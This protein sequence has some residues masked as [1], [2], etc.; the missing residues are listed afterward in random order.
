MKKN[1]LL[2]S[3]CVWMNSCVT[4]EVISETAPISAMKTKDLTYQ[5]NAN[6]DLQKQEIPEEAFSHV[7][8]NIRNEMPNLYLIVESIQ[9]CNIH[10]SGTYHFPTEFS[11][12]YWETDTTQTS[13]TIET[14]AIELAPHQEFLCPQE[15]TLSFIPQSNRAWN[16]IILPQNCTQTYL[17]VNCKIYNI[18]NTDKGYQEGKE[19]LIWGDEKGNCA[20]LAIPLSVHFLSNQEYSI[21]VELST[22]CTWYNINGSQPVPAL[23]PITFDVSVN[24]WEEVSS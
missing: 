1:L 5:Y 20:K 22:D 21:T 2:L 4:D 10:L 17:L 24:D 19:A 9:I 6:E 13:L 12:G 11:K 23:V 16:P 8:L 15:G 18:Y 7:Q 14:G 3:F